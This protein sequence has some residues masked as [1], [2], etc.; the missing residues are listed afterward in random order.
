M[1]T[2]NSITWDIITNHVR[3]IKRN[4]VC[5]LPFQ[6]SQDSTGNSERR[7]SHLITQTLIRTTQGLLGIPLSRVPCVR[8]QILSDSI[9]WITV[10]GITYFKQFLWRVLLWVSSL[11]RSKPDYS[12]SCWPYKSK[13]SVWLCRVCE[14]LYRRGNP[15]VKLLLKISSSKHLKAV[16]IS[17]SLYLQS[18]SLR[19]ELYEVTVSIAWYVYQVI[20]Y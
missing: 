3:S 13:T 16:D 10:T 12:K 1:K 2:L 18:P 11:G 19:R 4:T 9:Y 5:P 20:N 17:A 15:I 7:H 8:N 14:S 6:L